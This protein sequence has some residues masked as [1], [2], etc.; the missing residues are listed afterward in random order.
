[1]P[2]TPR[3]LTVA[4]VTW[5]DASY[6]SGAVTLAEMVPRVELTTAG[7]LVRE[8]KN[9]ITLALD[10]YLDDETWR[11]VTHIPK[12]NVTAVKRIKV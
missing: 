4:V 6:Q 2:A 3:K 12:V 8:D 9:T 1:M 11:H 5:Y 7:I 10:R